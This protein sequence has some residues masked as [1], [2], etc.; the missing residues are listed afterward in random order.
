MGKKSMNQAAAID[1]FLNILLDETTL[2]PSRLETHLVKKDRKFRGSLTKK[3][4]LSL[5]FKLQI[6]LPKVVSETLLQAFEVGGDFDYKSFLRTLMQAHAKQQDVSDVSTG[7]EEDEEEEESSEQS[8][9]SGRNSK[10]GKSE[11]ARKSRAG[12]SSSR[13]DSSRDDNSDRQGKPKHLQNKS[14]FPDLE[15]DI[16]DV[17]GSES[18]DIQH[19]LEDG[20]RV[21]ARY[22]GKDK[23]FPATVKKVRKGRSGRASTYDLEYDDGDKEK[24]VARE[25]IRK[26]RSG[27]GDNKKD[28]KKKKKKAGSDSSSSRSSN[29][30]E[31]GSGNDIESESDGTSELE[32]GL[33][34]EARYKGKDK[35]FPATVKKVRKGRSGRA[36]TYDL[37][38][39][40]GD[41]E[42]GVA[43]E[44]IRKL[45]SGGGD[46]KKDKKKKKKKAGSDSS[47]SSSS[48]GSNDGSG[49]AIESESDGTSELEEGLKVEARYKGKDKWFPATVKKVR[50]GRSGRAST[51]DLEYDDGDKEKG[52]A[53]ELIRKLKSG[54]ADKKKD[55]KKKKKKAGSDSSSSSSS[56]SNGNE[57]GSGNDIESESDGTSELEE[58]LKVEARYK[59]KDK[60]FAATVK[61]VRKSRS[62]RA[63]TY[64]LEYDDGDKEKGV[65]RELI[66]K[67]KSGGGDKK[68]DKKKKKEKAGSDSSSS[69]N[70]SNDGSGNDIESESDGTSELE[71]GLKVEARYNGK[72]KWFP[73]TV[74]KVRKGRSG[75]AS[76]YDLEYDDGD[77]EKDVARE[78]IQK[79]KSGGGDKKKDKKKKKKKAGSGSSSSSNGSGDGS[80]NDIESESDGTS[81]LEEG[82]KVEARYKGKDKWFPATVKKVRKG[83]SGRASTYDLEYDDGDKEK[84]VAR[85]LIRKLRSGGG[86]NKKDKKKIKKKAGSNSSSSSSSSSNDIESE[87]DGTSELEEGLKVEARYKGKD[88]W[89]PATVKKVR[90]GRSGRASTYDLEYD[91]GDKEK[92]V[93]R[94][95]IRKLKSGGGDK[96]KDTKK[97][98]KKAGSDGSGNSSSNDSRDGSG[99]G[100]ESE[101]DGTSELEEGLKVEA[102]YKGKDKWFP[103]TVKK[104]RKRRSGRASTYDLEYDDGDKEKDVARELI[105]KL[106]S[107][108]ADKKKDK[109]KEKK[110]A[111]SDSSS[112][113]SSSHGSGDGSGNDIE[114]ESDGTSE[115]EEGLK[116][117]ARY[118]GKDK[119]FPATVKKVRKGRSGRASTYD[120]EYDDG[121]KEKDVAREL[122]RKLRSGGGDNKKD[123]KKKKKKAGS[124][125][126]S[127]SSSNDNE[128]GSGNDI[129][130]ES[131]GTSELEEGLKVEARYKGKDKWFPATVKKVQKGR[132]GRAS[133]YDLEYDDGDK[134]KGVARELIRK[135]K[136]GGGDNKKD[137]KKK[138]KKAGS[139]SSS[140]SSSNDNENG[141]GNDIESESDGTSELEEGL[142]VE[143]RYK[144]KDKWFPAT[145][146]K[147]RKGRS[148]RASTYDLEYDDG[149]KEK[150]VA[151]ELIRKLKSG[152]GDKKKDKKKKKKKAGS[153]SSGSSNGNDN[154]NANGSG[155]AIESE[156]DGT[157]ELEAGSK[158]EARYKGKDKW[159][160]ATVKKVRKGRSG[161][162]STYDLEYDDGD[163]EKGVA[164]E[165]IRKLRSG[166]GD[167]K[168]DKK[169]KKKKKAG[170]DSSSSSSSNG[171]ND[172]SG[173]DIESESDGTSELEEG[174]KVEA[175][176]KGKDK[177]FPATVKKVRKGR[178]GRASTYDLEY[179]DGDKEKDVARELIRKLKS[180]GV[181][182]KKDKKKKKKKAGSDSSSSSSSSSNG[183]ENGSGNDIESESD[184]TSELEEGLKVEARYKGKDKWFPATVKKVRKGRSGRASTY[185]LEYDDGDK[186]KGVARELIR[187]LKSGGGDK[188]KD[189]K[190][191]KKKAGSD[192]SSSSSNGNENGS[193]N[194]IESESDG[195]SELEEGL[196][197]EARYKGKDKWFPATV[198]KV[199]KG[200]SGRASTYDLEYDDGDKEKDVARELIRKL[201]SGGGDN[202]KDKKKKKKKAGSGSSSSSSSSH[203]SGDG[204]G[205]DIESESDGTSELEE[206]SKVEAR[207]K[208]KDKW[209]PATVKKV[210]KGRSGRASTYDLEYD[211]GDKE[212]GVARELIRKLKSGGGDKKKDKK[213]KK[214]KAGSG[215][216]SSSSSSHGSGDGSGN[217]I[218]S[219]SDGTSE[220]EEG[221]KVEARYKGKDKWFPATVKKVRKGRSGRAS[222]Y[223]LE[224]DDGDKEKGVARELIRKLKSGGGDKK[225]DKKKKKKKAGPDSSSSSSS[226][227]DNENGS[228]ND[229]ESESDGTSELEEGLKVEARYKG[230]DK[231]F[232][233]TVKKVRKGRSGRASTYDL[234]YDDGDNEKGVARELIQKLKSGGG[235]KK[236]DK[237]KEKKKAGSDS[238]SSSSSSHGSGDGSGNDIESES[239]GTSELE[240]GLKVEARYK[241]KD[242]WFPATVKKVR[243]GRSG[244]ASTYD[245]EYDDGDKEKGVARELIRK[246]KSGGGDKKKDKKKKK[247]KAGSDSSSSSNGSNDGSGNDIESESDGTS[248]L[249]EGLKVEARYKGKDKWFPATVKKVRK[250]RSGRASTYDLE[251]DGG[252]KEKGVARELIR[253]LKSSGGDKKKDKKKKKKKAGPVGT[254]TSNSNGSGDGDRQH[255]RKK[256]KRTSAVSRGRRTRTSS[257]NDNAGMFDEMNT[258]RNR[259]RTPQ[260]RRS[261][262]RISVSDEA[263]DPSGLQGVLRVA[264][265]VTAKYEGRWLK[266]T[267]EKVLSRGKEYVVKFRDRKGR[268]LRR[269]FKANNVRPGTAV[270]TAIS[271]FKGKRDQSSEN[272]KGKLTIAGAAATALKLTKMRSRAKKR[273]IKTAAVSLDPTKCAYIAVQ[274][275]MLEELPE[276]MAVRY[277]NAT[278][279][280]IIGVPE[281]LMCG[282]YFMIPV[283][284]KFVL[285]GRA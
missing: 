218:E 129:E 104:V 259:K 117:E 60:W 273:V 167:K 95:L 58:G 184:G 205:N 103:A 124:D 249:E 8:G 44:L 1:E 83:R 57:N 164:R 281:H 26:L 28:K 24:D 138:K 59:G 191:K 51:Y 189:K 202:K 255:V 109:K 145:V 18:V 282:Q 195:T 262:S 161:R 20:A 25:L 193:G 140:S 14:P 66:R 96:K 181:D 162:A 146:K 267:V 222:T 157:S 56:S 69:S 149:D 206:G 180:G 85:E 10:R 116:V 105:R 254:T 100:I 39:D 210:R 74:K 271:L 266:G 99:N 270:S 274:I 197:V 278:K 160:P 9:S 45:R 52:V 32:E 128:N 284:T 158:V 240:E 139:D 187:K 53:R 87:S 166:G 92:G 230:K 29:G 17:S 229:I 175:R 220:L 5:L 73:A 246:L 23:W 91:D 82:L 135:L 176:Y 47:S 33:K 107:G 86:D 276:A 77:K 245:L 239:D 204:S 163:K 110:K 156:S 143:A 226:S 219:E 177:W 133:T 199:R 227:N 179:D 11:K 115:L 89:F 4:F 250:G 275:P 42:K 122:I 223:D 132:S 238:S 183:N 16:D 61:K 111:G 121:D 269:N 194:D 242:K 261:K 236:K 71:E 215:S 7:D 55:K 22:K 142:K 79:L 131:D 196:K 97:K 15:S 241:G 119:W 49:N 21:E 63:S 36:S 277:P 243:K 169:K 216:S 41:K 213:K 182:K 38:Y 6:N 251:Y 173:N 112:S 102:R 127:S 154:G 200:R 130:S 34:V 80:G 113:S 237:K 123:K 170:S 171:S 120:L 235:D 212:K 234:E 78:L 280:K 152:G 264:A 134:E 185:D 93:A 285:N 174:L 62:G 256:K 35:W 155:N 211:D 252:D 153:N 90:K 248:E 188:K 136:S 208:G 30:N 148:G 48:N 46:N 231:W 31:N 68:K 228:G 192:S 279:N 106:K 125:S 209:F 203:G 178:S 67:L 232:P 186:E 225:K 263:L 50:K 247:K 108:G 84:G 94:E 257:S 75:R 172:G 37:E 224:Y 126:S 54:G 150:G 27:G 258:T 65:A 217:D 101:S 283:P 147:V 168:K 43:R 19:D 214:K 141:S 272:R 159:F 70:G 137:K 12:S 233:A 118:K 114:S 165:L 260:K 201:R 76:T 88:K 207:Y 13:S 98:K 144:G 3:D 81:E 198:K 221:S 2:T 64:D 244:R 253:K 151:R 268:K 72:D 40:D 265:P 190:K